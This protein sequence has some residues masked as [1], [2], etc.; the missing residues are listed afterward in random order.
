MQYFD[1]KYLS[2]LQCIL[3]VQLRYTM[4]SNGLWNTGEAL[5]YDVDMYS[6]H[7]IHRGAE[8][9][10]EQCSGCFWHSNGSIMSH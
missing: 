10:N 9:S 7:G 8:S 5:A 6:P 4:G 3:H 2:R 1:V